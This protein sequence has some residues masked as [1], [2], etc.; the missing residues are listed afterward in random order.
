M[1]RLTS[2]PSGAARLCASLTLLTLLLTGCGGSDSGSSTPTPP[3]PSPPAAV[4]L[5]SLSPASTTE[6]SADVVVT[7]AGTGFTT[8]STVDWN[9]VALKTSYVS[10]TSLTAVVP[11]SDLLTVGTASV[12]VSN[13]SAG[14]ASSSVVSFAIASETSPTIA[15]LAP[16][17]T[18]AR[19]TG[20]VLIVNGINFGPAA[21]V[22]WNGHALPTAFQSSTELRAAVT[23]DLLATPGSAVVSVAN[24]ASS[25]G[26]SNTSSFTISVPPPAPTLASIAPTSLPTSGGGPLTLTGANFTT[27]TVVSF[28]NGSQLVQPTFV[29]STQ[30]TV[31]LPAGF[32]YSGSTISVAVRASQSSGIDSSPVNL[33][34]TPGI[35]LVTGL[36]PS[37]VTVLQSGVAVTVSGRY[38]SATSVVYVNGNARP[39]TTDQSGDLIVQLTA[40]DLANTGSDT[41]TVEDPISGNVASNPQMLTVMPLPPLALT[42][43]SPATVPAGNGAFTLTVFGNGFTTGSTIAWNGTTL[44]THYVSGTE[45]RAAIAA[46]L[47]VNP[48]ALPA[49]IPVTVVNPAG[50]GGTSAQ[51]P[52]T[53]VT[54]SLDA[55]SYQINSAHTG[56]ITFPSVSLPGAAAW[57]VNVGGSPATALIA[58][59]R[60]YVMANLQGNSNLL[61]LDAP[62]G[63]TVWGPLQFS[64]PA[65][66]AYDAGK[67]LVSS[68]AAF[69]STPVV[70]AVDAVTGATLWNAP[71]PNAFASEVQTVASGGIVY[72][73]GDGAV[74]AF[75]EVNGA[76]LWMQTVTGTDGSVAVTLDGV[77]ASPPCTATA[78]QPLSG[79]VLWT[80]N[81]GCV[82]GG[83][84]TPIVA[85]G[86]M[87]GSTGANGFSG[88]VY[89]AETGTVVGTLNYMST[90]AA[91]ASNVYA[92][93]STN[94]TFTLESL[95][96]SNNQVNWTFTG[97]GT[98]ASP[99]IVVN[100][101]VFEGSTNGHLYALDATSGSLLWTQT[102]GAAVPG[103]Y[104]NQTQGL[105][106]GDGLLVV[107][108][109][110]TVTAFVISP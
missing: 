109:G 22:L 56:S 24:D 33:M 110:N 104:G 31:S 18:V 57:S 51:L 6:G 86:R 96:A 44:T 17:T 59:G 38:F 9:G 20:L 92:L 42:S 25:G 85:G 103:P 47:V 5:M 30:L 75:S 21:T 99:P 80:L 12:T 2:A 68:G 10:D 26:T 45:L 84:A 82:G 95:V 76:Q 43:L 27:S 64:G 58:G 65:S 100:N 52:L 13:A 55:V 79:A 50:E 11:A 46:S 35:P 7:A 60:V 81:T 15:S 88:N 74:T 97:D 77:Y 73:L 105:T 89:D 1:T 62:T 78:L 98:L 36:S 106:A 8:S 71:V 61:A 4:T 3:P 63:A 23:P 34:I 90:P 19:S 108:A 93:V 101:Y 14:G 70:T 102:L 48:G 40:G 66:F 107:P 32:F 39:T 29:S 91:T 53:L 69:L 72:T 94:S 28:N 54:P 67:V 87:Y 16:S 41:I 49:T 83:G 37:S